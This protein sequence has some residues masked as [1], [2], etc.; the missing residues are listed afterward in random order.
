MS[1]YYWHR[2]EYD[3]NI[4]FN[5]IQ[6]WLLKTLVITAPQC[7]TVSKKILL[8]KSFE[9]QIWNREYVAQFYWLTASN[10]MD[11]IFYIEMAG[12]RLFSPLIL[13]IYMGYFYLH[14]TLLYLCPGYTS[15]HSSVSTKFYFLLGLIKI[16]CRTK[17]TMN[18]WYSQWTQR[19]EVEKCTYYFNGT[20]VACLFHSY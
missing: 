13:P 9:F 15:V 11:N 6:Q 2:V 12:A 7:G 20:H 5:N 8:N 4:S 17:M 18:I 19:R 1:Y 14:C 16:I 3:S 10:S